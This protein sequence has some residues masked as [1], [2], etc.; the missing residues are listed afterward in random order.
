M[1]QSSALLS[2]LWTARQVQQAVINP[3]TATRCVILAVLLL[4]NCCAHCGLIVQIAAL[5]H[6][7]AQTLIPPINTDREQIKFDKKTNRHRSSSR[8]NAIVDGVVANQHRYTSL[9]IVTTIS[10][11]LSKIGSLVHFQHRKTNQRALN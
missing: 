7:V 9:E 10:V 11:L 3:P 8:S 2:E 6:S 4:N 5:G 1:I